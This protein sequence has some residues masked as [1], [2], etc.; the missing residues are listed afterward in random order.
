MA[1]RFLEGWLANLKSHDVLIAGG[2][3]AGPLG[4]MPQGNR[5]AYGRTC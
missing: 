4:G 3:I 2:A 1:V 5:L